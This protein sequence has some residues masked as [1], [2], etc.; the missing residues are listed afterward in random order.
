MRAK[1][2]AKK[3]ASPRRASGSCKSP[4][5]GSRLELTFENSPLYD[6]TRL[7]RLLAI[8][9]PVMSKELL[10]SVPADVTEDELD[11]VAM[12]VLEFAGPTALLGKANFGGFSKTSAL[13]KKWEGGDSP[14][15][16]LVR[17]GDGWAVERARR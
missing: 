8:C 1:K 11:D 9:F 3:I 17:D 12:A 2:S 6:P 16:S 5:R 7:L 13:I 14:D 10:L 15:Y 4:K